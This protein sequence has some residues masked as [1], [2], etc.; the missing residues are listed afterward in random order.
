M[1][2]NSNQREELDALVEAFD[3]KT[4]GPLA[5][6]LTVVDQASKEE[7][8]LDPARFRSP[9]AG[10]VKG[11]GGAATAKILRRNGIDRVLA[12][13][14]GRTSRGSIERMEALVAMMNGWHA[15]GSLDIAAIE[16][17]WIERVRAFFAATPISFKMDPALGLRSILRNLIAKAEERQSETKGT[18]VVG[19]VMQHL[20][21]A[22]LEAA[23]SLRSIE[24]PH[25][26]SNQNDTGRG[27]DFDLGDVSIHVTTS[28]SGPLLQKCRKNIEA[29][30]KPIIVTNS[31]GVIAAEV[32]S[33]AEGIEGR[34][35]ILD[36]EHFM[37]TN[38]HE[39]GGF[40]SGATRE[41]IA[42]IVDRYNAIID[43]YETDPSLKIEID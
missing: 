38:F 16:E 41:V 12:S 4:K 22:K 30:A 1:P 15:A 37:V 27:G 34:V 25:H 39:I 7:L 33:K 36:F 19:T 32:L 21:G 42:D 28:P 17:Y 24:I 40:S 26:G 2:L 18:Q 8:P 31:S 9:K 35:D 14:G 5:I 20:V 11:A 29:G 23:F 6:A 43:K 13:E 10:Q 3:F